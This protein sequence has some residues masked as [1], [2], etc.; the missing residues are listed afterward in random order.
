LE[1]VEH[2]EKKGLLTRD[3]LSDLDQLGD[4]VALAE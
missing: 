1:A 4:R 2:L 3:E